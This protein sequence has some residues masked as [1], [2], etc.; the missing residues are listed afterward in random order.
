MT[1][2]A[3]GSGSTF[4]E[5]GSPVNG[6]TRA[7]GGVA[8]ALVAGANVF[9]ITLPKGPCYIELGNNTQQAAC[10]ISSMTFN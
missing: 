9:T 7:Y 2:N 8:Q 4:I 6:F 1:I 3:V 10:G 5:Y